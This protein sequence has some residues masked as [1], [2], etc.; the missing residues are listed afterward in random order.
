MMVSIFV[1]GSRKRD[2]FAD[3]LESRYRRLNSNKYT[4]HVVEITETVNTPEV[5]LQSMFSILL[6]LTKVNDDPVSKQTG[7]T[8]LPSTFPFT[9]TGSLVTRKN[10][11]FC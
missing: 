2:H 8:F 6:A 10:T 1:T 3:L 5:I 11:S 9:M 4:E 7:D